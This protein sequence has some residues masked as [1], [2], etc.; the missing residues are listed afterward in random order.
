MFSEYNRAVASGPFSSASHGLPLRVL[1]IQLAVGTLYSRGLQPPPG[2]RVL[3]SSWKL[4]KSTAFCVRSGQGGFP[5]T[6]VTA[7]IDSAGLIRPNCE[8]RSVASKI[9]SLVQL[10]FFGCGQSLA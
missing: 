9:G 3:S 5:A 8:S 2:Q 1:S 4:A 6:A 10:S 7:A